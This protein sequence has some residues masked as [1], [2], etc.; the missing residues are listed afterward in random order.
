MSYLARTSRWFILGLATIAVMG[1]RKGPPVAMVEVVEVQAQAMP[2]VS[3]IQWAKTDWPQWRGPNVD[4]NAGEQAI[5]TKWDETT[6]IAWKTDVPGRG[7]ASPIVV[8][9][10]VYLA[11]AI[12]DPP[13]Q[14]VLAYDRNTGKQQWEAI[15]HEG[16]FPDRAVIHQKGTLANG[17]VASDGK[18]I[19]ATFFNSG[20]IFATAIDLSGKRVWQKEVGAFSSKFGYAP[21]PLIYQ[22]TII[23]AADNWGGGYIAALNR[24]TGDVVWRKKRPAISTYSPP[25]IAKIHGKDQ[26]VMSGCTKVI[27]YNPATGDE[28]W[29]C[30]ATAEATCG[31]PVTDGELIFASGGFPERQ[32][33]CI[34][35][36]GSAK[37]VW[38]NNTRMYEPSM[39]VVGSNLFAVSDEGIAYCWSTKTGDARWKERI[40]GSFSASPVCCNGKIYVPN[41]SGETIIFEA[42]ANEYRE[43]ARNRL[44][45][46]S[47][48]SLAISGNQI[49]MRVG[50][51][52]GDSRQEKL[53]CIQG[54]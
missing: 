50:Y 41:L 32:T 38:N 4:G 23:V 54:K 18:R 19:F 31:T 10:T 37:M 2:D 24:D 35:G 9:S 45:N 47:Y 16:G 26:L 3:A 1:C 40:N 49:F 39:L 6:N 46:D 51:G 12:N 15:A 30:T 20:K 36:D 42:N 21:S 48:A 5:P 29:S 43:V 13:K 8:G 14:V 52:N 27:S 33:A 17:T 53:V 44:G 7:H 34:N 28:L 25:L 11:S 22:A